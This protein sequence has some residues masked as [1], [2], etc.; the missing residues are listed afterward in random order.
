MT[1]AE[2]NDSVISGPSAVWDELEELKSRIKRMERGGVAASASGAAV[3]SS[4]SGSNE[5]PRTATTTVTTISS[6]PKHN[7][8]PRK[9]LSP[10]LSSAN[11]DGDATPSV[12]P[13]LHQALARCKTVLSPSTYRVLEAMANDAIE[14]VT[15]TSGGGSQAPAYSAASVIGGA[16]VADRQIRRKADNMCR[17]VTELCI[18]LC[19]Q[20]SALNRS[21]GANNSPT[22]VQS[23]EQRPS[24]KRGQPTSPEAQEESPASGAY[25]R[26]ALR[27]ASLEPDSANAELRS[28]PS[29][30][31]SRIEARRNSLNVTGLSSSAANSPREPRVSEVDEPPNDAAPTPLQRISSIP[32]RFTRAGTSLLRSRRRVAEDEREDDSPMRPVSRAMTDIGGAGA[33]RD[34]QLRVPSLRDRANHRLSREYT[35]NEPLPEHTT[36]PQPSQRRV[37]GSLLRQGDGGSR[38]YPDRAAPPVAYESADRTRVA[39]SAGLY[40]AGRRTSGVS[41]AAGRKTRGTG[42]AVDTGPS[43]G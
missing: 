4:A 37:T 40:G 16:A 19:E 30:A 11:E 42:L 1:N 5:R 23:I 31:L 12:Y 9:A 15:L 32:S 22:I 10:T 2:G 34:P 27:S 43:E 29:R 35:S 36:A 39:S 7:R 26:H 20:N 17:T 21:G 24:S 38:R 33:Q 13:L 41:L 25:A 14:M 28:T 3:Q 8:N 18:A 6:S